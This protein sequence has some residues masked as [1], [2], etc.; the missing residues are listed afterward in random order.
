MLDILLTVLALVVALGILVAVH[1]LG[2]F[3]VARWVGVK[4]LRFSIGFGRPLWQRR[5]G[6]DQTEY[7]I[8][9]IPLGGY[10]KMLDEREGEV[11]EEE[12]HRAFNRQTVAKRSAIVVA[13]PLFNFLFAIF[14]YWW[15]F[16]LGVSGIKPLLGDIEPGTV[17]YA[18]GLKS[19]QEIVAVNSESTPTWQAVVEAVMPKVMLGLPV[20][21]TVNE[22]GLTSDISLNTE[23][24]D[25]G[26]QPEELL[27]KLGLKLYR[28]TIEPVIDKVMP[29]SVAEQAGLR[30]GDRVT[31]AARR[32]VNDWQEM[33]TIVSDH[34]GKPL[35]MKIARDGHEFDIELTP[36]PVK[37][38]QGAVGRI[39]ASVQIDKSLYQSMMASHKYAPAPALAAAWDKTWDISGLTLKMIGKMLS[40]SASIE[41]LSGP[42]GIAQY[43]KSSAGE[44][45]SQFLKFLGL[46]SVSLGILNLL[47][48]P[49]LD[50]GHLLFFGIEAVRGRP[51]S[52]QTEMLG[53]RIGLAFILALMILALYNDLVRLAG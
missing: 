20:E 22:G 49:V 42:I 38:E 1:E 16:V 5:F 44:G 23:A 52:E 33:V 36:E 51:V 24:L 15:M 28:P 19:G 9:T 3:L 35:Q 14:A 30:S 18:S 6:R 39:G 10:V 7:T 31:H 26:E 40:G 41:N 37:S 45:F 4:V 8:A 50:G 53:Q 32:P 13:G 34:P 47:P 2:H 27:I 21:L 12:R 46:I 29:G 25:V 48:I 17:A 43:A 11:A